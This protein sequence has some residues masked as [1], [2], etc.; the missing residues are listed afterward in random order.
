VVNIVDV[1]IAVVNGFLIGIVVF[2]LFFFGL[3]H[4]HAITVSSLMYLEVVSSI[5]LSYFIFNENLGWHT[6]LG[7]SL[8]ILSGF[9]LSFVKPSQT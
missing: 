7:G 9:L 1:G 4:I 8:I 5:V 3:K 6:L 2:K